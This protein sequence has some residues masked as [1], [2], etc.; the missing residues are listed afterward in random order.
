VG[1]VQYNTGD[2]Y[3]PSSYLVAGSNQIVCNWYRT[4]T[5]CNGI[6]TNPGILDGGI[7]YNFVIDWLTDDK[8]EC[9]GDISKCNV[10]VN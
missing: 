2:G 6:N 8:G 3:N 7:I 9:N 4:Q 5:T 1:D 10:R